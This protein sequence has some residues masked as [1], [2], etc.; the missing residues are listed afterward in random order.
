MPEVERGVGAATLR[1]ADVATLIAL[2]QKGDRAAFGTLVEQHYDL[3]FRTAY[4][5]LGNRAD[6]EDVAQ[7]VCVKLAGALAVF[8]GRAAFATWLYQVVLNTARDLERGRARRGRNVRALTLVAADAQAAD[9]E[10][11]TAVA[12]LWAAVRRLPEKQRDAVLL[13]YAE[14]LSHAA[15]AAIMGCKEATVSWHIFEA[16]RALKGLL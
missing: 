7:E 12:E 1:V 5:W 8:D 13:V 4:K 10:D 16:K 6:A 14:D 15:V 11:A 9:Q 3:I 2:A